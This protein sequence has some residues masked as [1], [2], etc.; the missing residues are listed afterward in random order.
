MRVTR[1][2]VFDVAE[3]LRVYYSTFGQWIGEYLSQNSYRMPSRFE[4]DFLVTSE[5][6]NFKYRCTNFYTPE[7]ERFIHRT[8]AFL[9]VEWRLSCNPLVMEKG[10]RGVA[11]ISTEYFE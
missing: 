2:E 1:G 4:C 5:T 8:D 3:D 7:S 6:A 9:A 11:F 10:N